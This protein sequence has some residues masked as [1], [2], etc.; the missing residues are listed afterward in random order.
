ML[1]VRTR[2][3]SHL[4]R[5]GG[6]GEVE[7]G[8]VGLSVVDVAGACAEEEHVVAAEPLVKPVHGVEVKEA[9]ADGMSEFD[10]LSDAGLADGGILE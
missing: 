6:S 5:P 10:A 4:V 9:V 3:I 7:A 2:D 8:E 1:E